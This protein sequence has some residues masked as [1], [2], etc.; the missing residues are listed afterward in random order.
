MGCKGNNIKMRRYFHPMMCARAKAKHSNLPDAN[1]FFAKQGIIWHQSSD[2]IYN[3]IELKILND[4]VVPSNSS[5]HGRFQ[6]M[7]SIWFSKCD[8]IYEKSN[9]YVH[10]T[11]EKKSGPIVC[12]W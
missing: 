4:G 8:F 5:P 7:R 6:T 9:I 3:N 1:F 10:Q 12:L 11:Q 2:S